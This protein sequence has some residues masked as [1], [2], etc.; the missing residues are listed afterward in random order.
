MI[1]YLY[2]YLAPVTV[3]FSMTHLFSCK[4]I[5][6]KIACCKNIGYR[7]SHATGG[8]GLDLGAVYMEEDWPS[9]LILYE[10]KFCLYEI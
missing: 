5:Y 6:D 7:L 9:S 8:G 10:N 3:F 2:K 4:L 1:K